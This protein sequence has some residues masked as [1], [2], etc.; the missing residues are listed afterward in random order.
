MSFDNPIR[1]Q[2]DEYGTLTANFRDIISSEY[3][4]AIVGTLLGIGMTAI[5][6][7]VYKSREWFNEKSGVYLKRYTKRINTAYEIS[8]A[9]NNECLELFRE[10]KNRKGGRHRFC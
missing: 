3:A 2:V 8:H 9:N 10:I 4:S 5:G 1:F 6:S 7:L